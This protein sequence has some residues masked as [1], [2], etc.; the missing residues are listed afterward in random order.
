M[1]EKLEPPTV[2]DLM[3]A[4]PVTIGPDLSLDDVITLL[5][6]A[7]IPAVPVVEDND[8]GKELLGFI[9]ERDC[10]EYFANEI[11]YGNPDVNVRSMMQRFPLCVSPETDVF[12]MAT[13]F[14]RHPHHHLPVVKNNRLVGII[15]R[16]DV[17]RG[18]YEF[19]R[20]VCA[21]RAES[22]GRSLRDFRDLVNLRFIIK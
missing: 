21:D 20:K 2:N 22:K 12:A 16:R 4:E 1:S 18:L 17:L 3:I 11:Y 8:G 10:L 19:E 15:S 9:T 6:R 14:T 13:I 7:D 5:I